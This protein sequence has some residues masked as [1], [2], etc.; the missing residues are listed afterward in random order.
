LICS[1]VPVLS[2]P[3]SVS[4]INNIDYKLVLQ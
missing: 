1:S 3:L 4:H 2:D